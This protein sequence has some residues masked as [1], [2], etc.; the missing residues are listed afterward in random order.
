ML[1]AKHKLV[2]VSLAAA[3]VISIGGI[4]ASAA[5]VASG[6]SLVPAGHLDL[7]KI[8]VQ[9]GYYTVVKGVT[10]KLTGNQ[11]GTTSPELTLTAVPGKPDL[12]HVQKGT[13]TAVKKI[14]PNSI[15]IL[16]G[17]S[18]SGHYTTAAAK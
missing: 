2:L 13:A 3:A 5:S 16:N 4:T 18:S 11:T 7:S 17:N 9:T 10:P 15:T 1:F 12:S 14:D 8:N 6:A